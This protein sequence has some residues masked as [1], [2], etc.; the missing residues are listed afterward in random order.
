M[1]GERLAQAGPVGGQVAGEQRSDPAESRPCRF[2][3]LLPDRAPE[4]L[5]KGDG[6]G[7]RLGLVETRPDDDHRALGAREQ[8]SEL[9]EK[10]RVGHAPARGTRRGALAA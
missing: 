9:C 6:R 7:P 1:R 5:G 2:E 8:L 10:P 3:G 4:L